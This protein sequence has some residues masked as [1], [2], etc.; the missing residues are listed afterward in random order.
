M[1]ASALLA[2]ISA[3]A[4]VQVDICA[5]GLKALSSLSQ[6]EPG[7]TGVTPLMYNMSCHGPP[8][9]PKV[10]PVCSADKTVSIWDAR[11]GLCAHTFYG[12]AHSVSHATYNLGGDTIASC[13]AFG[14]VK[15]WDV[16]HV[17]PM[18]QVDM[19]K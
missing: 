10:S 8:P 14:H 18:I 13:D 1:R 16:R 12:H 9:P 17:S 19:R 3:A 11:A 7:C 2:L 4:A 15:M 5:T 6:K